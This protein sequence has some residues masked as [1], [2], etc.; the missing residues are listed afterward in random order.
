M[1][2]TKSKK[3]SAKEVLAE[4]DTTKSAEHAHDLMCYALGLAELMEM[5][6]TKNVDG[7]EVKF[8]NHRLDYFA[9]VVREMQT[10]AKYAA[11]E[12][13]YLAQAIDDARKAEL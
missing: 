5:P 6:Q 1:E 9:E 3:L 7:Q 8:V 13:R 4:I 2:T 12:I 11:D 10:A